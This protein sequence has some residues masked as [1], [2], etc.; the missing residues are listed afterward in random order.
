MSKR[1]RKKLQTKKDPPLVRWVG[2]L[3]G[4]LV[5]YMIAEVALAIQPHYWHWLAAAAGAAVGYLLGD[6]WYRWRGDIV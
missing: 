3:I 6:G 5:A 1:T 4:L 2:L